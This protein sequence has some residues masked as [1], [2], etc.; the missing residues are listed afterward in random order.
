MWCELAISLGYTIQ[1][2][3]AKMTAKEFSIWLK[4]R[5]KFGPMNDV[6]R[7]DRPAAI[8]GSILSHAYGGKTDM[9]DLMPFGKEEATGVEISDFIN[10]AFGG[11]IKIGR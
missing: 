2:L 10:K 8:I 11:A 1:E 9:K 5:K 4:Y 3:Q 7:Y 6:R